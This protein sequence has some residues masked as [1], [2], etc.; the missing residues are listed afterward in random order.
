MKAQRK[1]K[2]RNTLRAKRGKV[3]KK[4]QR[5]MKRHR[6][7]GGSKEGGSVTTEEAGGTETPQ[8]VRGTP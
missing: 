5:V 7:K 8:I 6:Q 2:T 4:K 1:T 3:T